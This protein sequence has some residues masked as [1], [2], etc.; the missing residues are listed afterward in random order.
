MTLSFRRGSDLKLR[1]LRAKGNF[2]GAK[3]GSGAAISQHS[4]IVHPHPRGH[5]KAWIEGVNVKP[6]IHRLV[7][8]W[9]CLC[10]LGVK[11]KIHWRWGWEK[12]FHF[13][14][15]TRLGYTNCC[16]QWQVRTPQTS[17]VS[18]CFAEPLWVVVSFEV[19]L[20]GREQEEVLMRLWICI[21]ANRGTWASVEQK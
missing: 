16:C 15:V 5:S 2:L 21:Y 8:L 18:W 1:H 14:C 17:C 19:V 10:F 13:F 4:R 11:S 3:I 12:S 6:Q 20:P 9:S 7:D